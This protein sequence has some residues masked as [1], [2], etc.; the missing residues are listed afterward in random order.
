MYEVLI[1]IIVILVF[2]IKSNCVKKKVDDQ[3]YRLMRQTEELN[4]VLKQNGYGKHK[5]HKGHI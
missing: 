1:L 3:L 2:H 4:I 5:H